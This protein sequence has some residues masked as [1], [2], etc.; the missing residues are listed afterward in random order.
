MEPK[1]HLEL[2]MIALARGLLDARAVAE[3]MLDVGAHRGA[4]SSPESIWLREGRLTPK[5]LEAVLDAL[6]GDEDGGAPRSTRHFERYVKT[7][8][9]GAGAMGEVSACTD[10]RLGRRI[11]L[12]QLLPTLGSSP[13]A[14]ALLEREARITGNLEH[15]HIIPVYDAGRDP[16][17]GPYYVMRLVDQPT[18][19]DVIARLRSGDTGAATE[20]SLI[21]I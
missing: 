3:A 21:H 1:R 5:E 2:G 9:L 11:A 16:K 8:L 7:G 18:L 13:V 6:E 17:R 20:L 12:K 14:T 19:A 15:P 4:S 10:T